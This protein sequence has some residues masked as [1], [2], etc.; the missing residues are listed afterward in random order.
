MKCALCGHEF[1]QNEGMCSPACPLVGGCSVVCCARCG[2]GAPDESRS[3]L[4]RLAR[5]VRDMARRGPQHG[6]ETS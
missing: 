5:R 1:T 6:E 4:V 2:Y 3:T